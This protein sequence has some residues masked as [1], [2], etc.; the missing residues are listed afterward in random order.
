MLW[1]QRRWTIGIHAIILETTLSPAEARDS[2]L[3][4]RLPPNVELANDLYAMREKSFSL[5]FNKDYF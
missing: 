4:Q 3:C 2:G 1:S 5:A